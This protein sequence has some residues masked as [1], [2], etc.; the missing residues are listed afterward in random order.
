M[1]SKSFIPAMVKRFIYR[2]GFRPRP[3]SPFYSYTL[4]VYYAFSKTGK[5]VSRGVKEANKRYRKS[6]KAINQATKRKKKEKK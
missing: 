3:G 6:V 1:A 5:S 4:V 2:L